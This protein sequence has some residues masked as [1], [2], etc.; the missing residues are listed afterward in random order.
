[1]RKELWLQLIGAVVLAGALCAQVPLTRA[2][3]LRQNARQLRITLA[4]D[5]PG[6]YLAGEHGVLT[7]TLHN[8]TAQALEI[9]DPERREAGFFELLARNGKPCVEGVT[10]EYPAP[11]HSNWRNLPDDSSPSRV[12]QPGQTLTLRSDRELAGTEEERGPAGPLAGLESV[13]TSADDFRLMHSWAGQ[14]D[15]TVVA[16]LLERSSTALLNTR[17]TYVD[18]STGQTII[19]QLSTPVAVLNYGGQRYL[20]VGLEDQPIRLDALQQYQGKVMDQTSDVFSYFAR[21]RRLRI[22][23]GPVTA[24]SASVDSSNLITIRYTLAGQQHVLPLN[25]ERLPR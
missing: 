1:M 2:D 25:A 24:L 21:Y 7:M 5:R 9:P 6:P 23:P 3:L 12:L 22:L 19:Q 14:L 17:D 18:E 15:V 20:V 13:S 4:L 8:P 16:P 11:C 10:V